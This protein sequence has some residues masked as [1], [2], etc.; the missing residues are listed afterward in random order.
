MSISLTMFLI[1]AYNIQWNKS[2]NSDENL[3]A[4]IGMVASSCAFLLL[5]ILKISIKISR[6]KKIRN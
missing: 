2:L 5:L 6:E 3:I 4:L 1:N